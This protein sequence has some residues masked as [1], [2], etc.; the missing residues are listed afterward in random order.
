VR[1][2]ASELGGRIGR[3]ALLVIAVCPGLGASEAHGVTVALDVGHSRSRP[4]VTSAHGTP[5]F[6]LNRALAFAVRDELEAEHV[7]VRMI[8]DGGDANDLRARSAAAAGA[9][10]LLSLHH[11]SAQPQYLEWTEVEG[12]RHRV[13]HQ[14]AGF[15]L[16]V[17]R[18]NPRLATSL[19]CASAIG[20]AL[21]DAGMR[22]SS[23]H[24][25]KI[26]GEGRP[27]ADEANGVYYFD[28]LV[29]LRTARVPAVLLEAG[30]IVNP[31]D[32][33]T[34]SAPET[35]KKIAKAVAGALRCLGPERRPPGG[36][37][38]VM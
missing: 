11:D 29:V 4:G 6:E 20:T 30:V 9:D 22:Y 34:V 27:F 35:R 1:A 16:F 31:A 15:S 24:A 33:V 25:E 21:R 2:G 26:P 19:A 13:T 37:G 17:S 7:T 14:F 28:D 38:G 23:H 12:A 8:G 10:L 18:K 32:E 3:V 36:P 5:E